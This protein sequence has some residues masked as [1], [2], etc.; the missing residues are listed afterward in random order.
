MESRKSCALAYTWLGNNK[1]KL[2]ISSNSLGI[3][4]I[5]ITKG[6]ISNFLY[7]FRDKQRVWKDFLVQNFRGG[8]Y[9]EW[10]IKN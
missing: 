2:S 5:R 9:S 4:S 1:K 6:Q 10:R 8:Y 7:S 3:R